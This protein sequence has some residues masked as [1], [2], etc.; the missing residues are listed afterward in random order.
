MAYAVRIP[1][2]N[3][4]EAKFSGV[5]L[6]EITS[7]FPKYLIEGKVGEAYVSNI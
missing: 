1:L 2:Y 5:C 4:D 7:E 3:D 6:D